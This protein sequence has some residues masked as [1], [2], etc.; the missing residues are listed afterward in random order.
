MTQIMQLGGSMGRCLSV[1]THLPEST[2][3]RRRRRRHRR[4]EGRG[5]GGEEKN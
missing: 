2:V 5:G 3:R 1:F 4:E